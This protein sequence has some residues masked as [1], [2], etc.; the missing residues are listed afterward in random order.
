MAQPLREVSVQT[1]LSMSD[2]LRR[3]MGHF[4][5]NDNFNEIIPSLSG[6]VKIGESR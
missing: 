1:G 3:M 6:Q 2:L 5:R 4:L